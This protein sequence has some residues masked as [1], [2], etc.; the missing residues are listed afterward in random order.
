MRRLAVAVVIVLAV[1]IVSAGALAADSAAA[2]ARVVE[3]LQSDF[4]NDGFA[5]LAV[6]VRFEDV[7]SMVD[8]GAVNVVY[9]GAA[10]LT[11]AGSQY[12]TQNTP[13]VPG[14]AERDDQFG[15]ALAAGDF[16]NDGFAD[17]AIG[18]S[19]ESVGTVIEAGA[20]N[21]LYG[22][23]G[24]LSGSG[25][26]LF[27]Q[28]S[29]GVDDSP[30]LSDRLGDELTV[31]D[32]N[33]DGYTDLAIGAFGESVGA[34]T[35]AGAVSVLFGGAA[36]LTG[37]GSQ[38][39]S[40]GTPGVSGGVETADG[41]GFALTA[42]DINNDGFAD[43]AVG[44]PFDDVNG[45]ANAG[46]VNVLYGGAA[47]LTGSGSQLFSQNTPGVGNA[48][49]AD[50]TFGDTLAAG[51]FDSDGF[52]DLAIGVP[53]EDVLNI[54]AAG[55]INVLYGGA[56]GL[57][58]S[59]SQYLNQ[60]TPGVG[61][62]AEPTDVFGSSLAA[63]DFGGDGYADLAVG[64]P[65]ED[66]SLINVGAVNVLFGGA[67]GLTGSGSQLLT[68]NTPGV[69]STAEAHDLFGDALAAADFDSDGHADLAVGV[70]GE[71]SSIADV[72]AVN[73]LYGRAAGLTGSGSQ[74]FTQNTPGVGDTA[75]EGDQFGRTLPGSSN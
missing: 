62:S 49:E 61:S 72:G 69:G 65:D 16:D 20:V 39:L 9:G 24:G 43:L 27:T 67:A 26:Q 53:G 14:G 45:K 48:C 68:Q 23:A 46:A 37:S 56:A 74:L 33:N 38:F 41:F 11:G 73:V 51:D 29:A 25:S 66:S 54:S 64:V 5:D 40:R 58:A 21:V 52:V 13:G 71:D 6:G 22:G 63:D 32:F 36:G 50:D 10:G 55:A 7:G 2:E 42:G 75:E 57:T 35:T 47:G 59:G 19:G 60:D 12:F 18:V 17:L 1:G 70:T 34:A 4:D 3:S 8:G 28:N 44:V 30:E 15:S 31:G